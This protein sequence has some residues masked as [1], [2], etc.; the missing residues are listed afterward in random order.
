MP[1]N[2]PANQPKMHLQPAKNGMLGSHT[3]LHGGICVWEPSMLFSDCFE[4]CHVNA[5]HP[6]PCPVFIAARTSLFDQC[7][8]PLLSTGLSLILRQ[9]DPFSPPFPGLI[10]RA[11]NFGTL[12]G[13]TLR[14]PDRR[15]ASNRRI[16]RQARK[17]KEFKS[18]RT[19]SE[20]DEH[21]HLPRG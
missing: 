7:Q 10:F 19:V 15:A 1:K 16:S 13:G 11:V 8:V 20:T 5:R 12:H 2:A 4:F 14:R 21:A 3:L 9:Y 18:L 6:P 17:G